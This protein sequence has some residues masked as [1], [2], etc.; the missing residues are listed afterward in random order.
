MSSPS[1]CSQE[2]IP[3]LYI[4]IILPLY[5]CSLIHSKM[6]TKTNQLN[7]EEYITEKFSIFNNGKLN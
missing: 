5:A 7:K 4:Y 1:Q 3:Q 6:L 2:N